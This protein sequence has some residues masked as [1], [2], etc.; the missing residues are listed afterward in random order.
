MSEISSTVDSSK[1]KIDLRKL[2]MIGF[3]FL[4]LAITAYIYTYFPVER[5]WHEILRPA[6]LR[7][8]SLRNPY[9]IQDFFNPPWALLPIL[10]FAILP[11]SLG[12]ALFGATTL[13]VF[14]FIAR[15]MGATWLLTIALVTLPQTL[16]NAVQLNFEWLA[17]LGFIL[18]AQ[19]GLF[20]VLIKP[21]TGGLLA[22]YWLIEAYRTNKLREVF[23]IFGPVS[24]TF[25]L[26]FAIFGF[27]PAKSDFLL[28]PEGKHFWPYSVPI[29]LILMVIALKYRR[30]GFSITA[31]PFLAPYVQPYS[32]PMALY[33]LLPSR[34]LV[35][36]GII[37]LWLFGD[38]G[39]AWMNVMVFDL[40]GKWFR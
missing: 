25:L 34:N 22:A 3:A 39:K 23:R 8:L 6:S 26:S 31:G 33:G 29:G 32:L 13:F 10:P 16:Y 2:K 18:P 4:F 5:H 30:Q 19:V 35:Y 21:Q 40:L 38:V 12:N 9:E 17:A 7:L 20:F 27:Y 36:L 24:I 14:G 1:R 37:F 11:E 15:R 28:F